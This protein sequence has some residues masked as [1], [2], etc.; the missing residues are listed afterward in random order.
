[1]T[2]GVFTGREPLQDA[3][4]KP[5]PLPGYY[6][7]NA[8]ITETLPSGEPHIRLTAR[9]I[10]QNSSDDSIVLTNMS[11]DYL[12][13]AGQRWALWAD[14]GLVPSNTRTLELSG[15]VVLR[16]LDTRNAPVVRTEYLL[17]DTVLNTA[18]TSAAVR[19][20]VA[21]HSV[22]AKGLEADLE[23]GNVKLKADIHGQFNPR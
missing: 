17:V 5:P 10:Q 9:T 20:D 3:V 4:V 1:V 16:E 12:G 23:S 18:S 22:D 7:K 13:K 2:Y 21:E 15:D 6:F 19:I 11:A 8:V 14:R